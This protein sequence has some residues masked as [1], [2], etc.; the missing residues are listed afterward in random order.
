M[1]SNAA[2]HAPAHPVGKIGPNAVIRV[3]EALGA[4]E[5]PQAITRIFAAA[6]LK[7]YLA[8]PPAAMIDEHEV[9]RL[10]RVLH[11]D[12][13]DDRARAVG[14][15]AGELTA[16]Y[17][18]A[19]RIPRPVQHLLRLCPAAIASR[20]LARAIAAN[21]WTF[22]GT[23]AFSAQHGHPARFTIHDCPIARGQHGTE[24]W[25]DFYAATFE[26]LYRRLVHHNARVVE[27][28]CQ[29]QGA[30]ACVFEITWK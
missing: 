14:W 8:Q 22:V 16:D 1:V 10:H 2:L 21:A 18:L 19:H 13:G 7:R 11:R 3:I 26:R 15:R 27:V 23:G 24:P 12:L 20:L 4:M 9:V 28:A 25:C 30:P 29:A 5:S 6:R 17:L